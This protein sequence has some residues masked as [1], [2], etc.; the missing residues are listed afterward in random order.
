MTD[1]RA[2][3]VRALDR[4]N[5]QMDFLLQRL[6]SMDDEYLRKQIKPGTW[7]VIQIFNHLLE[8]EKL[9]LAYLKYKMKKNETL[10]R[11]SF[12]V[13]FRYQVAMI[14]MSL[15]V[16]F[17]APVKLSSPSN[18]DGLEEIRVKFIEARM[19][20]RN[21]IEEQDQS[22]FIMATSKH[23]R[24]GKI[25]LAKMIRFFHKHVQ[26]HEKQMLRRLITISKSIN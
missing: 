18:E 5:Q 22:Y 4:C 23:P 8:G 25:T 21:F 13:K 7:S 26:H 24:I 19:A 10:K 6:E 20:L 1:H 16:K 2:I 3:A 11:E 15:P 9:L 14:T 12:A 17:K